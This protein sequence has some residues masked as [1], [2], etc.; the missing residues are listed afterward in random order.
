MQ[1]RSRVYLNL[2]KQNL[3]PQKGFISLLNL[4]KN[5][6][7]KLA[8]ASSS[9]MEHIE[10]VLSTLKV[11]DYFDVIVSGQFVARGK[12]F[13]DI[14]LEAAK[15]LGIKPEYC[16]VLDDAQS[17]VE[18]AKN[19]NMKVIAVPNKFTKEHDF[20]KADLILNSL[21]EVNWKII[22]SL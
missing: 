4:L 1:K 5:H 11:K 18:S 9:V 14:N 8:V 21:E 7:V 20:S 16:L 22:S 2:L 3:H 12:P 15:K 6:K 17:G 10:T 13:P 19:A